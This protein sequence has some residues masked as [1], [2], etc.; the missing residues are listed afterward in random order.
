MSEQAIA[1]VGMSL[2]VPGAVSLDQ[3][4][5]QVSEGR[6][7]L[8]RASK[9]ALERAGIPARRI[10]AVGAVAAMPLLADFKS[11]DAKFFGISDIQ[12]NLLDPTHRLFL[13][14]AWEAMEQAG[15]VPGDAKGST[16]VFGSVES[17][18]LAS[19]LE[20]DEDDDPA[21]QM[22]KK[23]GTLI[24]YFSL[25]VSHA[26][27]L[28]GPSLTALATCASSLMAVHLAVQSLRQGKCTTAIA[29][30]SRVELPSLPAYGKGVDGMISAGGVIR[31]F[32]ARADG[33]IFG[34]GAGAVV[35]KLLDHAIRD[36]NPIQGV[37]RGSGFCNDGDP[38]DKL[39]FIAPT[40][41]GQTRAIR[42]AID[43]SG[44]D[45]STIG[46]VEC[47]GTGT[48]LGDP[49]EV[50]SL[51]EIYSGSK[52]VAKRSCAI[53]S[54]KSNI[55]HL[56]PAAGVVGL[57]KACLALSR[58]VI[59][60][61]ANFAVPN[62]KIDWGD[63]PFYVPTEQVS[64]RS[65]GVPKRAGV[66]AFGFGGSNA[67]VV[68]E[69][70]VE[71]P[72]GEVPAA[73]GDAQELLV[74]SAA[75]EAALTRRLGDIAAYCEMHPSVPISDL[76]YTLQV[77]RQAMPIRTH[78]LTD[79][80]NV[81]QCA[82]QLRRLKPT[83]TH[84]VPDRPVVFMFPGQGSQAVGMGHGLY[85]NEAVYR[86][87]FD[88]CSDVLVEALGIDLRNCVYRLDGSN[89]EEAEAQLKQTAVAQPALFVV[90]YALAK[91]FESWGLKP[92][93]LLG[94]S[95]GEY[96]AACLGGIFTLDEGLK[97]VA[98]RARLMQM[99]E[100]G[101][102][103][104]VSMPLDDLKELLPGELDLAA[105]NSS[106]RNVV[107][108]PSDAIDKFAAALRCKKVGIQKLAT[109]H[110]FHSRMLNSTADEFRRQLAGFQC[111]TPNQLVV[112]GVTGKPFTDGQATNPE[113][114][115]EQIRRPVLFREGLSLFLTDDNPIFLE[116]GPG[117]ALGGFVH[118]ND[119]SR[120]CFTSL[121]RAQQ[122]S[123]SNAHRNAREALASVW[124][125]GGAVDWPDRMTGRPGRLLDLP[126]YPFQRH[127]HWLDAKKPDAASEHSYPLSLYEAGWT[128]KPLEDAVSPA[129]IGHWVVF[130]DDQGCADDVI[131]KLRGAEQ[132][133]IVLRVGDTYRELGP[134][135]FAIEPLRR[136]QLTSALAGIRLDG[137]DERV[138]VLHFWS[139]NGA[140]RPASDMQAYELG[141]NLGF[142]SLLGLI[143]VAREARL[144]DGL[145]VQVYA[146]G[147]S[148]VDPHRDA[149]HP[150]K[151][152]LLG[153]IRVSTQEVS[154][155]SMR[156]I[157]VPS[158]DY[159]GGSGSVTEQIWRESQADCEDPVT[160]LRKEGRFTE[161]LFE[162]PEIP[163]SR[164][165]LRYGGTVLITGGVGGL[166]L[167]IA[168]SLYRTVNARLIL[169]SRWQAPPREEWGRYL[170]DTSKLGRAMRVLHPL[171]EAGAQIEIIQAN[172]TSLEDMSR[173]IE[174]GEVALGPIRGVVHTAG[175]LDDGPSLQKTYESAESV[176]RAKVESAYVLEALFADQ[177]LDIFVHFSSQ[178]S[179]RPAMGQVDYSSANAVLDRLA[180]RRSQRH[181]GLSC[182]MGWGAWRDAGMAWDYRSSAAS[183]PSLFRGTRLEDSDA[184]SQA[185]QHPLL[186]SYQHLPSGDAV[187]QGQLVRGGHWIA[188][189]HWIGHRPVVSATTIIEMIRAGFVE[190]FD[191]QG[192]V[193]IFDV[194]LIRQFAV[195]DVTQYQIFFA[196]RE[197]YC[198]VEVRID[199]AGDDDG[200]K[201]TSTA[202]IKDISS[203]PQVDD[204]V[205]DAWTAMRDCDVAPNNL[206]L[207]P[208]FNCD[209]SA[210]AYAKGVAAKLSMQPQFADEV[211]DY[212]LHP[213]IFDRC[214]HTVSEHLLGVLLPY[215]CER[216]RIYAA[217]PATALTYGYVRDPSVDDSLNVFVSDLDGNLLVEIEGYVV[218]DFE[219]PDHT[220]VGT[221]DRVDYDRHVDHRMVLDAPGNL[222][223]F[224][225]EAQ[226][227]NDL[228]TDEVRIRV[229]A[230]GLNFRDVL[231]ALGQLP[232]GDPGRDMRGSECTGTVV[233]VGAEVTHLSVGDPVI[234]LSH[235][236]FSTNVVTK[237]HMAT[238][239]PECLSYSDGA[240]IPITFLTV[241]YALNQ[242]AQLKSGEKILIH[243][244][245]GGIGLAAIQF[246]QAIG[247]EI[248]T[249]AGQDFKR[250][251]LRSLGV[252]HVFDSRSLDFVDEIHALTG[253]EGVDVVLNALAGEF[254][255][256]SMSLLKPFGRF[257]EIGKKDIYSNTQ[258]GLYP[259]RNNL[260][261][262]GIDLGQFSVHRKDELMDMF[263]QLML[264]FSSGELRPSPVKEF[265]LGSIGK[266][267]EY[268][269]RAEHIGKVVFT[270]D[271]N[272]DEADRSAERFRSR[273]GAGI[274]M[275]DG[276]DVFDRL[277]SSDE[278][279][280][281]VMIAAET[282]DSQARIAR[283]HASGGKRRFVDTEYRDPATTSEKLLKQIWE[284]T[285]GVT[286]IGIDDHFNEL[287]G[288]SINAIM[289]QASINDAFKL[290][291]TLAEL[292]SHP[293]IA[294]LGKMIDESVQGA[295]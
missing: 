131:R 282:L 153:P 38:E 235:D 87:I 265:P 143:Q 130:A 185:S 64:W 254:I 207:G 73:T 222:D 101:S 28:K 175:I 192:A 140:H 46:F 251:Y 286:P 183:Q 51:H 136:D 12:A 237:G 13:E 219:A 267:F 258:L 37:I 216:M 4:W 79:A 167:K 259:F 284:K 71:A 213:A 188:D 15:V 176:F 67:H 85:A 27:N 48:L 58:G 120:D 154:G 252:K 150:E 155:L 293:T 289:L 193:E 160:A 173:V 166:G 242:A 19:N 108:G 152:L 128:E 116:V 250:D 146:D 91:Q 113:Y 248:Y 62:P 139:V 151:G 257:L 133:V 106:T 82:A 124:A 43:D 260:S 255:P 226:G 269:A 288:D 25:R 5:T 178:A 7:C 194:A 103:L 158:E 77:G 126:T 112:S 134:G 107:S 210:A 8:T 272:M 215:S 268:L 223:S 93:A 221:A 271:Q 253:G 29:G 202:R 144:I 231:S 224:R 165:R 247:A 47:H 83:R 97:L 92:S 229:K 117:R 105:V 16:G 278:S 263:E 281:Q 40:A 214:V 240:S 18:Y 232:E 30:G 61:M 171:V 249:T 274:S 280:S 227:Q 190:A 6:D 189:E 172:A 211:R 57:I 76:A 84:V 161:H 9:G 208:R 233:E 244:G 174:L 50:R 63:T 34:D 70:Y 39:S 17:Y 241:D 65:N 2:R 270:I 14:C 261:F 90:E 53:G 11:F 118:Q 279:P 66:S 102:M 89:Q 59:P 243:A 138:R 99:C 291:L 104:A 31:P 42:E 277:L 203:S 111:T 157:D 181:P 72:Q 141:R 162:M 170:E 197:D 23:L 180:I 68:L 52:H 127:Q 137:R 290:D 212:A 273:F 294:V 196:R 236:S 149:L 122:D 295:S 266:G 100:P 80:D 283:H 239:L 109:S 114:W 148:Q 201:T 129:D 96:V 22:P 74:V 81:G 3:F 159:S 49:I 32:D 206:A 145:D 179:L 156:C 199:M 184:S 75:T 33:T 54:V 285:L 198:Q 24:D 164:N 41:S 276:L 245:A 204:A 177:A 217:M 1:V 234:A 275:Q 195:E 187:Y 45:P 200:W 86:E 182:A 55:G 186:G 191:V 98:I 119:S 163:R 142:H 209:L 168:E 125:A 44:V 36:G 60:P 21:M 110:A 123:V 115:V 287:G 56:G 95:L 121:Y 238:L 264:R 246:A 292:M 262:F 220:K 230:A 218:R 94:H 135:E 35:L 228:A 10:N 205:R 88:Y 169:T 132:S 78:L 256:A 225:L 26:L 20:S 147:L 69:E